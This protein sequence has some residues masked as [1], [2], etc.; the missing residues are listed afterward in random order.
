MF[1][2]TTTPLPPLPLPLIRFVSL[3]KMLDET[4]VSQK[5]IYYIP[6]YSAVTNNVSYITAFLNKNPEYAQQIVE[7]IIAKINASEASSIDKTILRIIHYENFFLGA[8]VQ[9]DLLY[10]LNSF[11]SEKVNL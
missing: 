8:C 10:L 1:I 4:A 9:K 2:G 11:K 5:D 6:A 3:K 7:I